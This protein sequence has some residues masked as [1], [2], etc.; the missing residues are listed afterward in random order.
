MY[1]AR[2]GDVERVLFKNEDFLIGMDEERESGMLIC[3]KN[4]L[5]FNNYFQPP[6]QTPIKVCYPEINQ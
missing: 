2:E 3:E 6:L 5:I 1:T 4:R